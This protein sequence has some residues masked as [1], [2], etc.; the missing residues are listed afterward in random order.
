MPT[1]PP[2][3]YPR[4][5]RGG[6]RRPS[7]GAGSHRCN[8]YPRPPRGGRLPFPAGC[9]GGEKISIHALREE[10]DRRRGQHTTRSRDFYPR[11]PRGGRQNGRFAHCGRPRISIH[12]LREEGDMSFMSSIVSNIIFLSTPSA[13]RATKGG[14]RWT[15]RRLYFYPRPP[16]GGRLD[17][18]SLSTDVLRFLSTPSARRA[19]HVRCR[20]S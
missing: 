3:F 10:G 14:N 11:P 2:Y 13:R 17:S 20:L 5:P 16:R 7:R 12:A 18:D 9:S 6:R 8:F 15:L 1:E 19:T 4:P